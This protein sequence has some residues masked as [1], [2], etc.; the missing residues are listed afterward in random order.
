MELRDRRILITGAAG[1]IG[2]HLAERLA[3]D[4]ELVLVDD[5][6]V[7]SQA[8]LARLAARSNVRIEK[9]DVTHREQ[10][11]ELMAG[12]EVVF[13]LA[14]SCLRTSLNHP[15]LSHDIN[16]G[17]TLS[18]CMAARSHRVKRL[19]YVSS[20]EVYG[21]ADKVPMSETHPYRPTTVYG[22][23]KLAGELYAL[24]YWRTHGL[25]V[26][27]VRPFNTYGPREP[28]AGIR[29]EVIPR[30]ILRLEG[31][32]P[33]VVYG[34]GE[35]TRDFIFV[36]DTVTGLLGAAECDGLV[37]DAV[38]IAFGHE[39]SIR[40][41]AQL[42]SSLMGRAE[43]SVTH[44]KARPG[45][46]DRHFAEIRKAQNLFGFEPEVDIETGLAR[47]VAWFRNQRIFDRVGAESAGTPNW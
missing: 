24:A 16:A 9:A 39:V 23:S 45:E 26:T 22:A 44:E 10:M 37:G 33:P 31:G 41:V 17:G 18:V 21:T 42:L 3:E 46:V 5:F 13:H 4:N 20:S 14:I 2:S 43:V 28:Y 6:S 32:Q 8:N 19:I 11:G 27:V 38:N 29:A 35:Q 12:V 34:D 30:F 15:Q 47:T 40:R 7:G 1:F 25:P 36:D